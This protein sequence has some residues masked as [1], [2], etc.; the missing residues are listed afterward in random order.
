M[1]KK[2]T[3]LIEDDLDERFRVAVFKAKGMH[4]GNLTEAVEEALELWIE[5]PNKIELKEQRIKT[6]I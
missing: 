5:N 3:V 6:R 2:L 1:A 4:K